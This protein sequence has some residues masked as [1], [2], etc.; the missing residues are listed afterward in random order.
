MT[1]KTMAATKT[2]SFMLKSTDPGIQIHVRNKCPTGTRQFPAKRIVLFVHA[3]VLEK[4][5]MRLISEVQ[6]FLD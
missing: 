5:R 3:M 1:A 4:H 6:R 2:E